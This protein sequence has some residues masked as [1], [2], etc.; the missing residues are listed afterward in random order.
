MSQAES[1]IKQK[2]NDDYVRSQKKN[3]KLSKRYF[4]QTFRCVN[5]IKGKHKDYKHQVSENTRTFQCT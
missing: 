3:V 5:Q 1:F 4:R 2:L